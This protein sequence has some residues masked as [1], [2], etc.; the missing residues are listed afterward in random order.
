MQQLFTRDDRRAIRA[1]ILTCVAVASLL[2]VSSP[3]F[4][5]PTPAKSARRGEITVEPVN[6]PGRVPRPAVA[7]DI[8]RVTMRVALPFRSISPAS[9]IEAATRRAPF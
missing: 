8:A 6:V 5:E 2:G 1:A 4:A 9:R 7:V 3:A